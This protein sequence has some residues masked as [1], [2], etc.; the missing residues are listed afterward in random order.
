MYS[1]RIPSTTVANGFG[2]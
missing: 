2:F 1:I